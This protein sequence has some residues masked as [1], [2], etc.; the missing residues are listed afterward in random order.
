M[1]TPKT[2]LSCLI[3]SIYYYG[4]S[5]SGVQNLHRQKRLGADMPFSHISMLHPKKSRGF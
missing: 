5:K 2:I 1:Y 3:Y 4:L